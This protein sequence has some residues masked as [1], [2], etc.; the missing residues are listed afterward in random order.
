MKPT[1]DVQC[2]QRIRHNVICDPLT[3]LSSE[4]ISSYINPI[5][6]MLAMYV[7]AKHVYVE[8]LLFF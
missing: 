7:S 1:A 3:F 5:T 2:P 8:T 6:R 4:H